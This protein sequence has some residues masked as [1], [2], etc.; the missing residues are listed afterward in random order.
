M[1]TPCC[2]REWK[3]DFLCQTPPSKLISTLAIESGAS[4]G[5]RTMGIFVDLN[6]EVDR[7]EKLTGR[8]L[9]ENEILQ[10]RY[11]AVM[12]EAAKIQGAAAAASG[13]AEAQSKAL[14]REVNELSEVI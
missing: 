7:Q 2:V 5:L 8:T 1:Q 10:L 6:K 3:L 13:S 11:N 14:A 9:G 4:R 12:R